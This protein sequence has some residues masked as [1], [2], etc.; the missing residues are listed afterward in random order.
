[1]FKLYFPQAEFFDEKTSRF[2]LRPAAI[3][4]FEHSLISVSKW[5]SEFEKP[6]LE[7]S[8]KS[9]EELV[10]YL[11]YMKLSDDDIVERL[12]DQH[13]EY[14]GEYLRKKHT[15]TKIFCLAKQTQKTSREFITSELIYYWMICYNIPFSCESWN[16]SRLMTLINVCAIKSQGKKGMMNQTD[17]AAWQRA[18]NERRLA[19]LT[20]E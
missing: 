2:V 17:Y 20:R 3:V 18:E 11:D 6:F 15:A 13:L 1:M 10:A 12:T 7:Q 14:V 9:P 4:P 5:E 8:D 16:L 19:E